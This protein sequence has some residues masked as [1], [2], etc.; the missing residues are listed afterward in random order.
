MEKKI[1]L[2]LVCTSVN[3]LGGKNNHMRNLYYYLNR[4]GFHAF[5]ICCSKVEK[6]LREFMIRGGVKEEDLILLP[7]FKKWLVIP[8]VIQLKNEFIKNKIDIAHTFQMQSD[9]LAGISARLAGIKK[10]YSC[11][12][13]KIVE[14]NISWCKQIFYKISNRLI[15]DWFVQTVVI[16]EGLKKELIKG[17]F[18]NPAKIKVIHLGLPIPKEFR[19]YIPN[20]DKIKQLPV[21]GTIS[22]L[23]KEKGISRF[24][25]AIPLIMKEIPGAR[26]TI[27]GKGEEEAALKRQVKNLGLEG[28]V[29]FNGWSDDIFP[30][31]DNIDIFILPSLRE[32]FGFVLLEAFLLSKPIIASDIEGIRDVIDDGVEGHL[33]DAANPQEFA[34]AVVALCRNKTKAELMGRNGNKKLFTKF[35]IEREIEQYEDLYNK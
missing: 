23:D 10:I 7:R 32:G 33:V 19:N 15:K 18:R 4:Q 28:R 35:T 29:S 8:F 1:R 14:D 9:I 6:E 34:H 2:A 31:M 20:Y 25:S 21:I 26:F 13:S 3:Q 11:F 30:F 22:R 5:I 27:T 17:N 24:I 16:S 12:E